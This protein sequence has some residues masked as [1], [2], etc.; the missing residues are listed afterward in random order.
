[1]V[2]NL[3]IVLADSPEERAVV[4]KALRQ[5]ENLFSRYYLNESLEDVS[6]NFQLLDDVIIGSPF[7]CVN[8]A[9]AD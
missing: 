8:L 5:C 1:L 4:L 3:T 6:F 9:L 7:R 2:V